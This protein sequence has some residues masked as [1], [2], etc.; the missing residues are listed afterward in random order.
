MPVNPFVGQIV[1]FACNFAPTGYALCHGQVMPIVQN[2]ALF[3]LIGTTYGGNGQSTFALPDL[4]GVAPVGVGQ[5]PGLSDYLL[6]QVGGSAGVTLV[7]PELPQHTHAVTSQSPVTAVARG[8][9]DRGTQGSPV[10]HVPAV[11]AAGV[12]ATY[13]DAAPNATMNSAAIVMSGFTTPT[14]GSLPHE[15]RQPF[16][17]INYCIAL[18]GVFPAVE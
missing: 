11:E 6:G 3:S 12:T 10:G 9:N 7:T 13:S 17:E 4:R 15:N 5:G 14:G 2:T 1:L 16:L 18:Q 8:R